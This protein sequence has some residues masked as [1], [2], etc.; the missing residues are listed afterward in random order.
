MPESVLLWSSS[1]AVDEELLEVFLL[2]REDA[3][4]LALSLL[5]AVMSSCLTRPW[6]IVL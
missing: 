5:A 3:D 1:P 6:I 4:L 2:D